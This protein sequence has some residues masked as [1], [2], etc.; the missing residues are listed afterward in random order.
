MFRNDKKDKKEQR[1]ALLNAEKLAIEGIN[2]AQ[3]T[4]IVGIK[5][6]HE[7]TTRA[8]KEERT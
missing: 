1:D 2:E 4:A 7:I 8:I 6:I 3:K 5:E